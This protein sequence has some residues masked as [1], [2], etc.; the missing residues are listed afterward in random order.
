[1]K[2]YLLRMSD[3]QYDKLMKL[4]GAGSLRA[5][6]L[7]NLPLHTPPN[8]KVGP[9]PGMSKRLVSLPDDVIE[10]VEEY[11]KNTG[12]TFSSSLASLLEK[13]LNIRRS[14]TWDEI[15]KLNG[16]NQQ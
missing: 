15:Q 9:V 10:R 5:Y 3:E 13:Q 8:E 2:T 4:K 12:H 7:S 6:I 1:M 16:G 11:E 14:M